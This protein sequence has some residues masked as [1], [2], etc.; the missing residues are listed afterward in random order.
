[1]KFAA[2]GYVTKEDFYRAY[3]EYC[4]NHRLPIMTKDRIGKLLP[5]I[6]PS[7][8]EIYKLIGE[9]Q[10]RSWSGIY[11]AKEQEKQEDLGKA[12]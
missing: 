11:L 9:K 6:L 7:V 2:E 5:T 3:K 4:V 8:G 1:V 10:E 12:M